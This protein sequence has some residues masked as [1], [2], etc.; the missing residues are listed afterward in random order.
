MCF[1]CVFGSVLRQVFHQ[2]PKQ[3]VDS[4]LLELEGESPKAETSS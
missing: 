4:A 1:A 3:D 2:K